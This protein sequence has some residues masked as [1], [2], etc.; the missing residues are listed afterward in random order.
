MAAPAKPLGDAAAPYA[1]LRDL[2]LANRVLANE[3]V[4]DAFGHVSTRHPAHPSRL[5]IS[6]SLAPHEPS[7][8]LIS[9][10]LAP[11]L[12]QGEDIV[13]LDLDSNPI[14]ENAQ[15]LFIERYI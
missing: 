10:A 11:S 8:Y 13:V 1:A 7:R 9:R 4:L 3:G 5:L 14:G 6:R 12:V 2:V 15:A